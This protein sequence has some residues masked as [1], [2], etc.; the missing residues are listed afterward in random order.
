MS[1]PP[2]VGSVPLDVPAAGRLLAAEVATTELPGAVLVAG[3]G[4][5]VDGQV[6]VGQAQSLPE[7]ASRPLAAG[8]PFDLASLTKVVATMPALLALADVGQLDLADRV[9][10]YL[11]AFGGAGREQVSIEQLLTHTA[12]LPGH[13]DFRDLAPELVRAAV[14]AEPLVAAPGSA[15]CYSDLGYLLAG[16]VVEA[17]TGTGLDRAAAEL[18]FGPMAMSSTMFCPQA[19]YRDRCAATEADNSGHPLVGVVHDE[20][21]R[22]LGGVAGHAGLFAPAADLVAYLIA[23]TCGELPFAGQL[24]S[25]AVSCRTEGLGGRRGLGWCCRRDPYDHM[26]R[27]WPESAIGHTGFTGTSVALDPVGGAWAV[28]LTNAVHPGRERSQAAALRRRVHDALAGG[29]PG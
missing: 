23:W 18:V 27:F 5:R 16:F 8:T 15:V 10:R 4:D 12:G 13:R 7:A 9:H 11:P 6:V 17:V 2:P 3:R 25:V 19:E 21:A 26:G 22:A 1:T 29:A 24:R 28:L 14:L 20:N